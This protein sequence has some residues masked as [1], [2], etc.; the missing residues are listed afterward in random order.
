MIESVRGDLLR[1]PAMA[2]VNA[3]NTVGVMGKGL[4]LQFKNAH[5]DNFKAYLKACKQDQI[6]VGQMLIFDRGLLAVPRY[7]INFPTKKHW[8][9]PSK[10]EY[11]S[12]GLDD[13]TFQVRSLG[14]QS[15][16]IPALGTGLGGLEWA[17]VRPLIL[18]A[19]VLLPDVQVWLFEPPGELDTALEKSNITI[20][21]A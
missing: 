14:I 15:I 16:A 17:E 13:L 11:I 21:Q 19:F 18:E 8:R 4:A 7:I 2:L 9:H 3:V 1:A 6:R 10:L 5:P 20:E 12:A